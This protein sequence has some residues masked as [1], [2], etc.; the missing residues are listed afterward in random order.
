MTQ[1]PGEET[2]QQK[3]ERRLALFSEVGGLIGP[4]VE[5]ETSINLDRAT[6]CI[7]VMLSHATEVLA[8]YYNLEAEEA[9]ECFKMMKAQVAKRITQ[10]Q[11][12]K[13]EARRKSELNIIVPGEDDE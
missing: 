11:K 10:I 2:L 12:K 13:Q 8:I 4:V 5:R 9:Q 1:T 3:N 6:D 7:D